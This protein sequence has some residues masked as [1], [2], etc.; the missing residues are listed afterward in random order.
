MIVLNWLFFGGVL[1]GAF[2]AQYDYEGVGVLPTESDVSFISRDNWALLLF[3]IFLWN[4]AVSGFGLITLSGLILFVL[5]V[6]FLFF[7]ALLWGALLSTLST[8]GLLI[9]FPTLIL[10]GEGYVL[11]GVAGVSLGLSWIS[12]KRAY[13]EH[14][15]SRL[16]SLKRAF[17]DCVGIYVLVVLFLFVAAVV[18]ALSLIFVF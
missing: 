8:A 4:L 7:R 6:A 17:G 16:D 10:K 11:C 14:G 2:L 3:G 9:A 13:G 12:P 1:V 15:L 5:P 18:E